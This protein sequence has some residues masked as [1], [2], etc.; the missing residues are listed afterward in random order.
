[1]PDGHLV[2]VDR[3]A[4]HRVWE[5][6][7]EKWLKYLAGKYAKTT[8]KS[9]LA[10]AVNHFTFNVA[11]A[12]FEAP[13]LVW[14]SRHMEQ[15]T[16]IRDN[17]TNY[18]CDCLAVEQTLTCADILHYTIKQKEKKRNR[19]IA[20][21]IPIVG[22]LES[23]RAVVRSATKSNRGHEREQYARILL[24]KANSGCPK[25]EATVAELLGSYRRQESWEAMFT[26]CAWDDGWK[27]VM[28]KMAST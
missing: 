24:T 8:A 12:I 15:L 1:M 6:N 5:P 18:A 2:F 19:R 3:D 23:V 9:I 28:D 7:K 17:D 22:T 21:A 20:G 11:G 27:L 4:A 16:E 13:S 25:A 10:S 26:V 14:T